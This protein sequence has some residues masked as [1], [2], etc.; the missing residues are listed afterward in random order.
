M[1]LGVWEGIKGIKWK[2]N[3]I[4]L[5]EVYDLKYKD[6]KNTILERFKKIYTHCDYLIFVIYNTSRTSCWAR[7]IDIRNKQLIF[8]SSNITPPG[9]IK[10]LQKTRQE[11]ITII[12]TPTT[13]PEKVK[14]KVG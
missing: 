10:D 8:M 6:K 14:K 11:L 3:L 4:K 9:I 7:A 13:F 12:Q 2:K 1:T 5:Y